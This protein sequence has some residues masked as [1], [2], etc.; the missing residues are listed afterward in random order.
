MDIGI[1]L[2]DRV[3]DLLEQYCFTGFGRRNNHTALAF[4]YRSD[5]VDN[6]DGHIVSRARAL[7]RYALVWVDRHKLI[8]RLSEHGLFNVFSVD[9]RNVEQRQ[10]FFVVARRARFAGYI[11]ARFKAEPAYLGD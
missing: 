6:P 5:Q 9:G 11:I 10:E 1:I 3:G 8:E 2:G 4:A 7:K